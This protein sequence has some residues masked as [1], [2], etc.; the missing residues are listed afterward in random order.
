[1]ANKQQ[2]ELV[3]KILQ[4]EEAPVTE[5]PD[6]YANSVRVSTGIYDITLNFGVI[7]PVGEGQAEQ[8]PVCTLRMSPQHAKMLTLILR[9]ALKSYEREFGCTLPI[10]LE[11]QKDFPEGL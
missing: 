1:M 6:F 11:R 7:T 9:D 8:R 4:E 2:R 5:V 3:G 10:P